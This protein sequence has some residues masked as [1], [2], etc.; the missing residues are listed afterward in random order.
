MARPTLPPDQLKLSRQ[1][2]ISE[3]TARLIKFI[4]LYHD[5]AETFDD[6][7]SRAILKTYPAEIARYELYQSEQEQDKP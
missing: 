2:R 6:I 4:A 1:V 5:Q 7:I 3:Q